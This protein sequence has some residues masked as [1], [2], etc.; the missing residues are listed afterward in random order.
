MFKRLLSVA[1]LFGLASA[2][3]PAHAANCAMRDTVVDRLEKKYS[4][5]FTAGGLQTSRATQTVVEVWSSPETGTFTVMLTN[6]QGISCIVATGTDW[7]QQLPDAKPA[8]T[9][10]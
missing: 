3:S 10:S 5:Q 8:G 6:P 2:A 4:E 9:P 1:L 7:F